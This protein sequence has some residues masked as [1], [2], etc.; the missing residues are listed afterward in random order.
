MIASAGSYGIRGRQKSEKP[1]GTYLTMSR[2]RKIDV[3]W[4][5]SPYFKYQV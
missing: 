5:L 4:R 1:I 3:P 2:A